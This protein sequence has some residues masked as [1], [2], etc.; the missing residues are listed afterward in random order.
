[1]SFVDAIKSCFRHARANGRAPRSEYWYFFL[2]ALVVQI[3]LRLIYP[4]LAYVFDLAVFL[5]GIAVAIRRLHDI[6]RSAWWLLIGFVPI[7]GTILLIIWFCQRSDDGENRFGAP[8][9]SPDALTAG[10]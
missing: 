7:V 4:P 2:F 9:L 8:P 5:P 1:M 3:A 6:D 10:T